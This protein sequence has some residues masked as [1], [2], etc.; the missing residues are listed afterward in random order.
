MMARCEAR[1]SIPDKSLQKAEGHPGSGSEVPGRNI[2]PSWGGGRC[3]VKG[4]KPVSG[5]RIYTEQWI[6]QGLWEG[7]KELVM[8]K[9]RGMKKQRQMIWYLFL[10]TTD[11]GWVR[12]TYHAVSQP[13]RPF[14]SNDQLVGMAWFPQRQPGSSDGWFSSVSKVVR[15]G[16]V[17]SS[18]SLGKQHLCDLILQKQNV[19]RW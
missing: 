7:R 16:Q 5:S 12:E 11:Q 18:V 2:V 3:G 10:R 15:A 14:T 1:A 6:K 4:W 9:E 8:L 19:F 17:D 13:R